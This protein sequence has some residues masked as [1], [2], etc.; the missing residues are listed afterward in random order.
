MYI[1]CIVVHSLPESVL[2][3]FKYM[4]LNLHSPLQSGCNFYVIIMHI[5]L[6][7]TQ[8]TVRKG[9]RHQIKC[10]R[11]YLGKLSKW[12]MHNLMLSSFQIEPLTPTSF[13]HWQCIQYSWRGK[14]SW[15]FM[16]E[17][18]AMKIYP[19]RYMYVVWCRVATLEDFYPWKL[20][21]LGNSW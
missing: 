13:I 20:L 9:E 16:D 12:F 14:F 6:C 2:V 10:Q 4:Y 21:N 17:S 1:H 19:Q 15:F 5:F 3:V 18:K 7:F 8:G 11:Y